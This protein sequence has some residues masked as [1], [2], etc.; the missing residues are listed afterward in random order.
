MKVWFHKADSTPAGVSMAVAAGVAGHL[1]ALAIETMAVQATLFVARITP[2]RRVARL[3]E[4]PRGV[5]K[6]DDIGHILR[7]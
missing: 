2:L 5:E 6:R 4:V 7:A 3:L 1:A